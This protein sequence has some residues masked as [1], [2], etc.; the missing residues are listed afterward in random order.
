MG[1]AGEGGEKT[2]RHWG[3]QN[4]EINTRDLSCS[5]DLDLP[6]RREMHNPTFTRLPQICNVFNS[7]LFFWGCTAKIEFQTGIIIKS[8]RDAMEK[9]PLK[10]RQLFSTYYFYRLCRGRFN[11]DIKSMCAIWCAG[12]NAKLRFLAHEIDSCGR[13]LPLLRTSLYIL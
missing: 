8:N 6:R 11:F 10:C 3:R 4:W 2:N 5:Q 1:N 12:S 7:L 9:F 13:W